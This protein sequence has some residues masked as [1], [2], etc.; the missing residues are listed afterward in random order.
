[1]GEIKGQ[2]HHPAKKEKEAGLKKVERERASV[3]K[4]RTQGGRTHLLSHF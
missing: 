3:L 2:L 1:M 4:K